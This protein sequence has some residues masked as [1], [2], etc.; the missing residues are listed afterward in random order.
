MV[1]IGMDKAATTLHVLEIN[2]GLDQ[3]ALAL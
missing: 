2:Y 3:Y 1:F